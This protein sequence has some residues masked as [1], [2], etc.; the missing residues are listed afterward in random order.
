MIG[1]ARHTTIFLFAHQDDET[2]VFQKILDEQVVGR[3]IVCI[4]AT[5][6]VQQEH[7]SQR[8]NDESIAVLVRLGVDPGNVHFIGDQLQI[9]DGALL[10]RLVPAAHWLDHF[11]AQQSSVTR[12]YVPAWEGGHPDH[13]ALHAIGV[14]ISAQRHLL[15]DTFQYSLYNGFQCFGPMFRTLL[16]LPSNGAVISLRVP[17]ANRL[18]FLHYALC[19]PSQ[20]VTWLGLFPMMLMHYLLWGTQ[21]LQGVSLTR[22][23]ER[24]HSE[25]L[26]YERRKFSSYTLVNQK[27]R[28]FQAIYRSTQLLR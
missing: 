15:N 18:R 20:W 9:A 12:L 19:Y 13:D 23:T 22:L 7:T 28:E 8:R 5:T 1:E 6:G 25:S 16:P 10:N 24:P 4:Y 21:Q 2:G 3:E 26:Y 17:W 14:T 11:I 27:V